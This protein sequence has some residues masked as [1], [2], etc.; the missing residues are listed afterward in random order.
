[1][2]DVVLDTD[3]KRIKPSLYLSCKL[4]EHAENLTPQIGLIRTE[5]GID[6]II[7]KAEGWE[8][9]LPLPFGRKFRLHECDV[10]LVRD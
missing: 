3:A 4:K 6:D 5:L 10:A 1:M 9:G 2:D 8:A 7:K